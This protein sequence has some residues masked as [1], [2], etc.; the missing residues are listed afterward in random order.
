MQ[1][2]KCKQEFT[3]P[4]NEIIKHGDKSFFRSACPSC[5]HIMQEEK[6]FFGRLNRILAIVL[7]VP[8]IFIF[9]IILSIIIKKHFPMNY[10]MLSSLLVVSVLLL[11]LIPKVRQI[12]KNK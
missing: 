8:F 2:P 10:I 11:L 5:G 12:F 1:C 3:R 4:K 6:L 9:L 7:L